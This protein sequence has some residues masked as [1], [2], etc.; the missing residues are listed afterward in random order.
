MSSVFLIKRAE[1]LDD[2]LLFSMFLNFVFIFDP[3]CFGR[4]NWFQASKFSGRCFKK[5]I[6]HRVR[7]SE[8]IPYLFRLF[9]SFFYYQCLGR[10]ISSLND[11]SSIPK[12]RAKHGD[13]LQ[14]S[15]ITE[16]VMYLIC[17][18]FPINL[19]KWFSIYGMCMIWKCL[20]C[21]LKDKVTIN[22]CY[23]KIC[24]FTGYATWSPLFSNAIICC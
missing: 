17:I 23:S 15:Q 20:N 5:G 8:N 24:I 9:S 3:I 16:F 7:R 10:Y 2:N 18:I 4:N 11:S 1:I 13:I 21:N 6:S 22:I 14:L 19:L 12:W